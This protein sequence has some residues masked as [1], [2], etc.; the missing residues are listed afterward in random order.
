LLSLGR[1]WVGE[2]ETTRAG[3]EVGESGVELYSRDPE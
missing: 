2:D 3:V 1:G